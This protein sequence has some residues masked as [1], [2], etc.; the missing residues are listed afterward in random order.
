MSHVKCLAVGLLPELSLKPTLNLGGIVLT[1]L[2]LMNSGI[3]IFGDWRV[4]SREINFT[5]C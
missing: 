5:G 3:V 2:F 1:T 4:P